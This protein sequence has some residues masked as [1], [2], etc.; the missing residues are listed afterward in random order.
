MSLMRWD[1]F[2]NIA[3]LQEG[4]NRLFNDSFPRMD[5][6]ADEVSC[7]KWR[8]V[9]DIYEEGD[10]VVLN[11]EL[12]GIGKNDISIEVK[13]DIL[14]ISG[15]RSESKELPKERYFIKERQFGPF[16]RSFQ[17]Q[18]TVDPDKIRASFKEGILEVRIPKPLAPKPCQVS[19]NFE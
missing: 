16:H 14:I 3:A 7:G 15:Q 1:P 9:V 2:R 6:A 19:V 11:A 12:P 18:D 4:I 17:L 10:W 5:T 13:N 8:P